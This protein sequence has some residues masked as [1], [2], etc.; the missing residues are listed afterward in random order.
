MDLIHT[1]MIQSIDLFKW[2]DPQNHFSDQ[3]INF[4]IYLPVKFNGSD[5]IIPKT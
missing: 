2:I 3:W 1:F 5:H 4:V